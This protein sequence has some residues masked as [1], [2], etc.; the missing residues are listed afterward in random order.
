MINHF[1]AYGIN[2]F[3][4]AFQYVT[5]TFVTKK[6]FL[7][8]FINPDIASASNRLSATSTVT[9]LIFINAKACLEVAT[10]TIAITSKPLKLRWD[11][12]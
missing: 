10:R 2:F 12:N 9:L 3:S 11:K 5:L 7:H 8:P 1:Q 4:C 6:T